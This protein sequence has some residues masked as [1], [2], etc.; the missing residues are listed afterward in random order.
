MTKVALTG[1][2]SL[3][4]PIILAGAFK[5]NWT[6][7][8]RQ[9]PPDG[10]PRPGG[11]HFYAALPLVRR[12]F[13]TSLVTWVGTD[14]MG[15]LYRRCC[16]SQGISLD[17]CAEITEGATP[18]CFLVYQADGSCACLID[19]GFSGRETLTAVQ[20][21][22]LRDSDLVCITVGPSATTARA[23]EI[24]RPDATVAWISK[25]DPNSF[26]PEICRALGQRARFIFCNAQE[27]RRID[28][29]ALDRPEDQVVVETRG[30]GAVTIH[31]RN[32]VINIPVQPVAVL[33]TT[34]AGDTL[35]G[36]TLAAIAA[37]ETDLSAAVVAGI[38][39]ARELLEPRAQSRANQ[40][41]VR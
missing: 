38:S 26:T 4:Y 31:H 41:G 35:A 25:N 21:Q 17:A 32:Q 30:A 34:G 28:D 8:I 29:C 23:L 13:D 22:H 40:G 33:D 6:T 2:A 24:V 11:C 3:D 20:E 27:R 9:R 10:W 36:G 14:D 18:V 7:E 39:A 15:H 37:G 1:Y 5:A 19:F 16:A 12:G